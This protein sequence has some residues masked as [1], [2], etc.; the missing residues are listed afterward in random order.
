MSRRNEL[1]LGASASNIPTIQLRHWSP[2]PACSLQWVMVRY[3]LGGVYEDRDRAQIIGIR[4]SAVRVQFDRIFRKM[5][6]R[7]RIAGL[8]EFVAEAKPV[9]P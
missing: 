8:Y 9:R 5:H 6:V 3:V 7:S 4:P 1:A 2:K